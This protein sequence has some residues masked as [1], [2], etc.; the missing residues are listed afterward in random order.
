MFEIRRYTPADKALWDSYVAKARNATF[1]FFRD[2]MDY[3]SDRF[4]DH[5]LMFF[6]GNRLHSLLP[7][8]M[9]GTTLYSHQGLTYGGLLM[10]IHVTAADVLLLF[11]ELNRYL[12]D[13]GICKVVYK[14]IPWIYHQVPSEEDLYSLFWTCRARLVA[15]DISTTVCMPEQV[16][17]RNNR[18][19]MFKR[20]ALE[21]IEVIRTEDFKPF[22]KV[23]DENLMA[24]HQVHPVHTLAEIELLH[25]RF[26]KHIIQY[27]ALLDGEVVAGMTFYQSTRVLHN[28]YCS[29]N[30][31]GR[32]CGAV[33]A[34]MN[35]V[36]Y[37]DFSHYQYLDLGRSTEGNGAVLNEGLI[38]YKEGFGGRAVCYD[39]YE[40]DT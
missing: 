17:W 15:R 40:W 11:A 26:P 24:R 34:I 10:D 29:S 33:D 39:T 21:G 14:P 5:S 16:R 9:V 2:Y 7:A 3:H 22:W 20:A 38:A 36:M 28:Q 8:N 19:R 1:L 12:H 18:C 13:M 25:A 23:L 37:K 27:N 32:Q 35:H 30:S 31:I 6:V 4:Q